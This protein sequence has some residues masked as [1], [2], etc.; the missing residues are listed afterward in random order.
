MHVWCAKELL[1]RELPWS[2]CFQTGTAG[3][4]HWEHSAYQCSAVETSNAV[5][6][7]GPDR[8]STCSV[9]ESQLSL[10]SR[11]LK[12]QRQLSP[13]PS[14]RLELCCALGHVGHHLTQYTI[15]VVNAV[16]RFAIKNPLRPQP[17][18]A[19]SACREHIAAT[20]P[21]PRDPRAS[22]VHAA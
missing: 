5:R 19:L 14:P 13:L 16:V 10:L 8:R 1:A 3:S 21:P 22:C 9:Q 4:I 11:C 2:R 18:A 6:L 15:S 20:A 17:G 7:A 12:D